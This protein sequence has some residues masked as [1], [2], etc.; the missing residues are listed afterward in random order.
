MVVGVGASGV[1]WKAEKEE[2]E[3]KRLR[4]APN[5]RKQEVKVPAKD[6]PSFSAVVL[7]PT[8]ATK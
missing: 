6:F 5:T 1:G 8:N 3:R 4:E 7:L 2:G